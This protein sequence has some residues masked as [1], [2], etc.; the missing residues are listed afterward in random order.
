MPIAEDVCVLEKMKE[1]IEEIA[2]LCK[3]KLNK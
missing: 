3:L 2:E 1:M